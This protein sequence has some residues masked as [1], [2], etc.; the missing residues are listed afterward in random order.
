MTISSYKSNTGI[1]TKNN[2]NLGF[3]MPNNIMLNMNYM[4]LISYLLIF[5]ENY[6]LV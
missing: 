2:N 4:S 3:S 6:D 1:D 5:A